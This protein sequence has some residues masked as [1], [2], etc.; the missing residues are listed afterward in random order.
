MHWHSADGRSALRIFTEPRLRYEDGAYRWTGFVA[1][2]PIGAVPLGTTGLEIALA[3]DDGSDEDSA[4][5]IG[6]APGALATSRPI[7]ASGRRLQI[8][9]VADRAR[10]G[11][12]A[13]VS[14]CSCPRCAGGPGWP[15]A[16][17]RTR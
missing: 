5:P 1:D 10:R 16:G 13:V 11:R 6:A 12:R 8:F 17:S 9:A 15:V 7:I 3:T 14:R 2:V 4:V